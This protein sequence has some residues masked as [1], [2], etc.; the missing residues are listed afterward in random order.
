MKCDYLIRV[1]EDAFLFYGGDTNW[2]INGLDSVP[3]KLKRLGKINNILAH[4]PWK[5]K[6]NDL[7]VYI[8]KCNIC[9]YRK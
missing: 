4:Q 7:E 9:I 2:L 5:I 8:K 3:E 6:H 1:A